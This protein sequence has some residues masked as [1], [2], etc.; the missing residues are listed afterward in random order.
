MKQFLSAGSIEN[1]YTQTAP[2][3][4]LGSTGSFKVTCIECIF[5]HLGIILRPL[6]SSFFNDFGIKRFVHE[7]RQILSD[8]KPRLN[9]M[10]QRRLEHGILGH[11]TVRR[12][13]AAGNRD[14]IAEFR[15]DGMASRSLSG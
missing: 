14:H 6:T 11:S 13:L 10:T 1:T 15:N 12:P 8:A 4:I 3:N 9:K 5:N 2:K 7:N